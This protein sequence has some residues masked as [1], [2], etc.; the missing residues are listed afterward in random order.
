MV[1]KGLVMNAMVEGTKSPE[2]K[3]IQVYQHPFCFQETQ[4]VPPNQWLLKWFP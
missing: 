1:V 4:P 2:K 3:Q